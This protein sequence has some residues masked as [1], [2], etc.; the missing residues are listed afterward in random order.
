MHPAGLHPFRCKEPHACLDDG[1]LV[2]FIDKEKISELTIN[3]KI[4]F[5]EDPIADK[6][7]P[8][9]VDAVGRSEQVKPVRSDQPWLSDLPEQTQ[10]HGHLQA[11]E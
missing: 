2:H 4:E 7:F 5:I 6:D 8:P 9:K 11:I 10:A 3:M 1:T